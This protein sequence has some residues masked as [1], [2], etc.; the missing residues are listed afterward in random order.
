MPRTGGRRLTED[1]PCL[2]W[3]RRLSVRR[4]I[5]SS[6]KETQDYTAAR[7][8][9]NSFSAHAAASQ[10]FIWMT[11]PIPPD[12]EDDTIS[13]RKW[14]E[15]VMQYRHDIK[16]IAMWAEDYADTVHTM[17]WLGGPEWLL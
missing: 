6:L 15:V 10:G 13:E 16:M 1:T 3:G 5:I 7:W 2:D 9:I 12:P 14:E 17:V 4:N 8:Y 11:M